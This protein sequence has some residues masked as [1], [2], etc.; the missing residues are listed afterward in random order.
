MVEFL[1]DVT[2]EDFSYEEGKRYCSMDD[3]TEEDLKDFIFVRQ[4]NSPKRR[5]WWTKFPQSSN[6]DLFR[7]LN[8]EELS[9]L[10][11]LEEYRLLQL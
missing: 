2:G 6:G 4:P 1:K 8:E 10:E 11:R 5:N 7:V 9:I 3:L